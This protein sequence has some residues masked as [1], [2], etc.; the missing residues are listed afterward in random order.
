MGRLYSSCFITMV[1][2]ALMASYQG[3]WRIEM[4]ASREWT[5]W[6]LTPAGWIR[7]AM[8]TDV[9]RS[10]DSSVPENRVMTCRVEEH[11]G[12]SSPHKSAEITW[13]ID[14]ED[15]VKDLIAKFGKCPSH[16]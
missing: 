15:I 14:D 12:F 2:Y 13:K 11:I 16:L 7:G 9:S 3:L 1:A 6:H 8:K 10:T 4:S 5:V